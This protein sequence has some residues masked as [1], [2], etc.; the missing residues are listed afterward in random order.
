MEN[1]ESN[2]EPDPKPERHN[3]VEEKKE[4]HKEEIVEKKEEH[5]V[6]HKKPVVIHHSNHNKKPM[7]EKLMKNPW[8]IVSVVLAVVVLVLAISTFAGGGM[9]GAVVGISEDAA[10]QKVLDFANGQTGGGVT[11]IEVKETSGLY[12]VVVDYKGDEVPLYITKDGENLVQ[13]VTPLSS[14]DA[15]ED[16]SDSVP[17]P[18]PNL[19][20]SDKPEVELFVM[21]H[22]PYGTQAEKGFL[23][24]IEALGDKI[25][26]SIKFV[27]YFLHDPEKT[28][29][30][31]QVC[32]REEQASKFTPYL[33]C[34]LEDGNSSRCL[35]EVGV[36]QDGLD[37]CLEDNADD[38]YATDSELSEGYGVRGSPSLVINGVMVSSSR[39]PSAYLA[40]ICSA[41]NEAPEVCETANLDSANPSPGFGY[42]TTTAATT[43]SC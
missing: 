3:H 22:C 19:T 5:K 30:P 40:S 9:T 11:L 41:F 26:A 36:N 2:S 17:V 29:T 18:T 42:S 12:E 38:Y 43:A 34:F 37:E 6:E 21:T 32:L 39:S 24:A 31:I 23:P 16:D 25:D 7:G 4:E 28:E 27:H 13:G 1:H 20:K 15:Q 10:A 33:E 8:M 14:F 35:E